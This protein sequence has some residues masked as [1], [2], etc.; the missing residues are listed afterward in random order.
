MTYSSEQPWQ[1]GID[2]HQSELLAWFLERRIVGD[3]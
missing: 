3:G 1:Q 2:D